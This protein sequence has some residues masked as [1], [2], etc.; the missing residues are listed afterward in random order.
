[1]TVETVGTGNWTKELAEA[2]LVGLYQ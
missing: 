2:D 1:M